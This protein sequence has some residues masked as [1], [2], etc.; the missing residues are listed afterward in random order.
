MKALFVIRQLYQTTQELIVQLSPH[1]ADKLPAD[2]NFSNSPITNEVMRNLK[3]KK[4]IQLTKKELILINGGFRKVRCMI[5]P[6]IVN[7]L[8]PDVQNPS[9]NFPYL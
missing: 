9:V 3:I 7:T 8:D 4:G 5:L 1:V 2:H 6:D